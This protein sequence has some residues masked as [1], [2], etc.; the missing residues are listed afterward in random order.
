MDY[1]KIETASAAPKASS[2]V[3]TFRASDTPLKR[4]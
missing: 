4:Q 3:E 2:M 1:S